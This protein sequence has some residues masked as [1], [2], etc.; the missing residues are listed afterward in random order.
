LVHGRDQ[1][2]NQLRILK[3]SLL[4]LVLL[5]EAHRVREGK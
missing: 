1:V 3:K 4:I 2:R 5:G